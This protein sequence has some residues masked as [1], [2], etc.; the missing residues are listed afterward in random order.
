MHRPQFEEAGSDLFHIFTEIPQII[1]K[2][3][4]FSFGSYEISRIPTKTI[5]ILQ[6]Y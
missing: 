1:L 3:N 6:D 4:L 5:D 2:S